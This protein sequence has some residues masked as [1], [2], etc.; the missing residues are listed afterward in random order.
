MPDR[1]VNQQAHV[2]GSWVMIDPIKPD[3][4]YLYVKVLAKPPFGTRMPNGEAAL[5]D[6]EIA[7]IKRWIYDAVGAP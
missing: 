3:S 7:C 1:L 4:S 2:R 6:A 5:P